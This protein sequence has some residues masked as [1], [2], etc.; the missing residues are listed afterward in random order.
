MTEFVL[1]YR[2]PPDYLAE[3]CPVLNEGGVVEVGG[4]TIL[5]RGTTR[6]S[7]PREG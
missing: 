6:A 4:L 1:T 2:N 5:N 7:T 3:G